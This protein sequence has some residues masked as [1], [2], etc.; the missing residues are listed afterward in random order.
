MKKAVDHAIATGDDYD[1]EYRVVKPNGVSSWVLI[2]GKVVQIGEK[3]SSKLSG[4]SL[5]ISDLKAA[6]QALLES[7]ARFETFAQAM[8]NQIWSATPDGLLDWRRWRDP[9]W[10]VVSPNQ[11]PWL[12]LVKLKIGIPDGAG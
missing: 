7:D 12:P 2:R 3:P 4:T 10:P 8:P 5:D 9:C 6:E 1:I 11:T